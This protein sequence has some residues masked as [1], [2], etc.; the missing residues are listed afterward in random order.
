[1][2][3]RAIAAL[4][5]GGLLLAACGGGD[6]KAPPAKTTTT[7]AV[8]TS[9]AP[10]TD[11]APLTGL[12]GAPRQRPALF[13]KIDNAPKARPQ[14]GLNQADIIIE[15]GVE[16]G[17]T[18]FATIFHS[19]D[20]DPVGPVRS[21]RTS[22][23]PIASAFNHPL[24]AYSG[25]NSDFEKLLDKAP[26]VNVG[27][28]YFPAGYHRVSGRPA[29][30][31]YFSA[32]Q[33]LFGR[34]AANAGPPP[35][36]FTYRAAGQAPGGEAASGAHL[37]FRGV[38]V[39]AVDW[40]WDAAASAWKR[41]NNGSPHVDAAGVQVSAVNVVIEF[42]TYKDTGYK[43]QSGAAVPEAQLIGEGDAWVLTGGQIVKG[44]WQKPT[45]EAVTKLVMA[46][47]SVIALTPGRTW[48]ELPAPG[49]AQ[50]RP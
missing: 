5:V 50:V 32:T 24:F 31:N 12:P 18:R 28:R 22:D 3:R 33:L 29:P 20:A 44:R 38:V 13:V 27:P 36:Q 2:T 25:T 1:M 4:A 39:T 45:P 41:T 19:N 21:A 9:A 11:V 14:A 26:I 43:D 23:I 46:D 16:G 30:Y 17:I 7:A 49:L 15:E 34:A 48:V 47:G 42:V 37:E 10:A 6:K 40:A 35:P 8:T